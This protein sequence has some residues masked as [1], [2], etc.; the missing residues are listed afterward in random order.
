MFAALLVGVAALCII[1]GL[2]LSHNLGYWP[3]GSS[4]PSAV[5]KIQNSDPKPNERGSDLTQWLIF[6]LTIASV[7]TVGVLYYRG[8]KITSIT[9]VAGPLADPAK[10]ATSTPTT[11]KLTIH[12]ARYGSAAHNFQPVSEEVLRRHDGGA[13]SVVVSNNLV[14][15]DPSPNTPKH[16]EVEYSYGHGEQY[17]RQFAAIPEGHLLILPEDKTRLDAAQL[18]LI[19][20]HDARAQ[21][22][23]RIEENKK[24]A[25]ELQTEINTIRNHQISLLDAAL[26][27]LPA[28]GVVQFLAEESRFIATQL[29]EI[30]A[31]N[32][33]FSPKMDLSRPMKREIICIE[34]ETD[35]MPVPW[36][37]RRLMVVADRY[38]R[39]I[40]RC[41]IRGLPTPASI[42]TGMEAEPFLG[43]LDAHATALEQR[44][45]SIAAIFNQP[46]PQLS[47]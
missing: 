27:E 36:Q 44:A 28:S 41:D 43:R 40:D 16:L 22:E 31:E 8:R 33:V 9:P 19:K 5:D 13:I 38:G 30:L 42:P 21:A 37:R 2:N 17:R 14:P 15:F 10:A 35:E 24:R 18:D 6:G 20:A 12:S 23:G 4:P 26:K 32:D 1:A 39:L 47:V 29:R 25:D 45:R 34:N 7:V 11:S 46:M 3:H